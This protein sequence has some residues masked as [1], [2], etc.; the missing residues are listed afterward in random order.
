M[1]IRIRVNRTDGHR[2]GNGTGRG[3]PRVPADAS[4]RTFAHMAAAAQVGCS[5][6]LDT[7][8]FAAQNQ[9]LDVARLLYRRHQVI[10]ECF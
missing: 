4:L 7:N 1:T 8:Y 9:G 3:R 2:G 10:G 5:W 6:C